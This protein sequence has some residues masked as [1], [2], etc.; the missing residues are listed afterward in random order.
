MDWTLVPSPLDGK[1]IRSHKSVGVAR[2]DAACS[3]ALNLA[4]F[5]VPRLA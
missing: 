3:I 2:F 1:T 4:L 5:P